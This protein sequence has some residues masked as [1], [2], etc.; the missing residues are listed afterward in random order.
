[1]TPIILKLYYSPNIVEKNG[2]QIDLFN[3]SLHLK[4]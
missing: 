3:K 1:M 4:I 2:T